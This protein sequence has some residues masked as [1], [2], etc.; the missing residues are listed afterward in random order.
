MYVDEMIQC[1]IHDIYN[2]HLSYWDR[3]QEINQIYNMDLNLES[4]D[5]NL[6]LSI[7]SLFTLSC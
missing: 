3:L 6:L 1:Y 2:C 5:T 7:D 4:L